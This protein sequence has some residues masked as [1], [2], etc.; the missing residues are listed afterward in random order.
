M[1]VGGVMY[2]DTRM[3]T[4]YSQKKMLQPPMEARPRRSAQRPAR[5]AFTVR[6]QQ[7]GKETLFTARQAS[8]ENTN[9]TE[10]VI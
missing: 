6:F 5:P 3:N 4:I 2:K 7:K 8:S 10:I 1:P 9:I